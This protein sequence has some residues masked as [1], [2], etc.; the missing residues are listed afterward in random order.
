MFDVP[1]VCTMIDIHSHILPGLDDGPDTMADAL[2]MARIAVEDGIRVVIATPHCLNGLYNNYRKGILSA[3]SEFNW[4]LKK[5][6]IPLEVLPGSEVH[7]DME[8]LNELESGRLMTLNDTGQY[9]FLELPDQFII[10][11]LVEFIIRLRKLKVTPI[12]AHPE[13]NLAIQRN[14]MLLHDL[15]SAGALSQITGGSLTGGFG[16]HALQCCLRVIE[17]NLVHFMAT[18]AHSPVTR[19]PRLFKAVE[20]LS[21]LTGKAGAERMVIEGPGM[22]IS[23]AKPEAFL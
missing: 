18:D 7:L 5:N 4:T 23:G 17:L 2:E 13:R 15:I 22:V 21:V 12:I 19:P 3:C 8:I 10:R 1:P 9:F 14:V 16:P 11:N 20:K 6:R